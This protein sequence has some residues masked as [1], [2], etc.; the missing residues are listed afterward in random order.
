MAIEIKE[1]VGYES[2]K[3]KNN[4]TNLTESVAIATPQQ[5]VSPDSLMVDIEGIHADIITINDTMYSK[6]CLEKALPY[7]TSPYE[8][9]VIMH[10]NEKDGQIVGRVKSAK[11]ID[12]KRSGTAATLF[13]CNIGDEEGIKGVRNGTLSTVSIGA[14]AFDVR[15]SICGKNIA[16]GDCP[17]EKGDI[18]DGQ[19]CYWIIEDMIPKEIS[20]VVVPSDKYALTMKVYKPSKKDIKES[21]EVK[22]KMSVCDEIMKSLT[23]SVIEDE[24]KEDGLSVQEKLHVDEEVVDKDDDKEDKDQE[25]ELEPAIEDDDKEEEEPAE[26]KEDEEKNDE[27]E[28]KDEEDSN[29]ENE[30]DKL[31]EELK[32]ELAGLKNE[33]KEIKKELKDTKAQLKSTK[34]MKEAADLELAKFRLQEKVNI[35]KKIKELKESVGIACEEAEEMAKNNSTKELNLIYNNLNEI[36]KHTKLPKKLVMESVVDEE[37]DNTNKSHKD[38]KESASNDIEEDYKDIVELENLHK[39]LFK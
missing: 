21:V 23:E 26:D 3:T 10:H 15:C 4:Y 17:H 25:E 16:E 7:W 24:E 9:P 2:T 38:V 12:S 37:N 39:R 20:Y 34:E 8:R 30:K 11:M 5:L 13:T 33:M 32:E 35:A 28:I 29:K 6:K 22:K 31:I 14:M 36:C 18:Y 27:E 1:Y 19:L